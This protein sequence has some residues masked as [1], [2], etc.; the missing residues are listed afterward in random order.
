MLVLISKPIPKAS[1]IRTVS[2]DTG[3]RVVVVVV[4][5]VKEVGGEGLPVPIENVE[6]DD[7]YLN[8]HTTG[9]GYG[10]KHTRDG[11]RFRGTGNKTREKRKTP[12]LLLLPPHTSPT[13][14]HNQTNNTNSVCPFTK[15]NKTQSTKHKTQNTKH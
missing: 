14:K 8:I 3:R 2:G 5:M 10:T 15:R 13:K 11:N 12:S 1:F 9:Y 7:G 6:Y 4:G